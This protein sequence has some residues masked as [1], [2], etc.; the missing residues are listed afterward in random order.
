MGNEEDVK[1]KTCREKRLV[2]RQ[3]ESHIFYLGK[4]IKKPTQNKTKQKK[5]HGQKRPGQNRRFY[6]NR[7]KKNDEKERNKQTKGENITTGI[8]KLTLKETKEV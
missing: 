6:G 7:K 2:E 5:S 3:S 8:K 4:A 1:K